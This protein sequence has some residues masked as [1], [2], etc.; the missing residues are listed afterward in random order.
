MSKKL[1]KP[2]RKPKK[3]KLTIRDKLEIGGIAIASFAII[4]WAGWSVYDYFAPEPVIPRYELHMD[5]LTEYLGTFS[6]TEEEDE[7]PLEETTE[8]VAE[9]EIETE[10]ETETEERTEVETET[11]SKSAQGVETA[12]NIPLKEESVT[13]TGVNETYDEQSTESESETEADT[14]KDA[15]VESETETE[16]ESETET[17]PVKYTYKAAT[18]LRVR[19]SADVTSALRAGYAAGETINVTEDESSHR[20]WYKV[21]KNGTEGYVKAEYVTKETEVDKNE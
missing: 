5:D 1:Y 12:R 8:D 2:K 15:N 18:S 21:N 11:E 13:D 7:I 19:A 20:G 16:T 17:E 9:T 14:D 4:G 6:S 3:E 10:S